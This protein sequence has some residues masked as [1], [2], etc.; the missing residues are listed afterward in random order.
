MLPVSGTYLTNLIPQKPPFVLISSLEEVTA[1]SCVTTFDIGKEHVLCSQ[2][3]LSIAGVLENMAQS[4][5]CKMGYEDFEAR[6]KHR[7]G[8][9]GEMKD[10]VCH[11]LPG[12]G[13]QLRTV[14][15]VD[16]EVFGAVT[17]VLA[18][19]YSGDELLATCR[20]KIF[21]EPQ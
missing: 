7:K 16:S 8:F 9:I 4:A 6:R 14:I 1:K 11:R 10:L 13:E 21:F 5:G 3:V 12:A 17:I 15:A 20:L 19:T 18:S 2:G